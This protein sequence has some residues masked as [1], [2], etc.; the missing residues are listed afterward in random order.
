M[1]KE[2]ICYRPR[3]CA[4][5]ANAVH[6]MR[7]AAEELIGCSDG[8]PEAGPVLNLQRE[9]LRTVHAEEESDSAPANRRRPQAWRPG[10]ACP[11]QIYSAELACLGRESERRLSSKW[12]A[13]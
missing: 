5:V 8:G 10:L 13:A 3:I 6:A 11:D 4:L 2:M 9:V 12:W 1:A 7:S